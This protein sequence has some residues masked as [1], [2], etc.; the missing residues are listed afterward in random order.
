MKRQAELSDARL[1]AT[2]ASHAAVS[3]W[4]HC[5]HSSPRLQGMGWS[6]IRPARLGPL[7]S[8]KSHENETGDADYSCWQKWTIV[9][10]SICRVAFPRCRSMH[11]LS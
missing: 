11:R 5:W 10:I 9:I 6:P 3:A 7:W 4:K 8:A 2:A 1:A